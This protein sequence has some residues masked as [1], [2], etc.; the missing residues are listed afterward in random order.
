M[1]VLRAGDLS[2]Q[3]AGLRALVL[4]LGLRH[5]G[6][7]HHA[8]LV[9]VLRQLQALRIGVQTLLQE[10]HLRLCRTQREI[11]LRHRC[12]SR[13]AGR[14]QIIR[15]GLGGG[16]AGVY[17]ARQLAPQVQLPAGAQAQ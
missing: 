11:G 8:R 2:I 12:L 10:L 1:L 17:P 13:Q 9:T 7:R 3:Q 5:I 14:R 16:T 6:R 4:R 15:T